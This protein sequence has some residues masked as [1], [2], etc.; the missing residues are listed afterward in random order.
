MK[1]KKIK[2]P[3]YLVHGKRQTS[4]VLVF[5]KKNGSLPPTT[6]LTNVTK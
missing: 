2:I 1:S 5:S 3:K 6:G 4:S